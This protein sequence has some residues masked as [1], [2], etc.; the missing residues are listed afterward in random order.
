MHK[1]ESDFSPNLIKCGE[2]SSTEGV[3]SL[4][5]CLEGEVQSQKQLSIAQICELSE[6]FNECFAKIVKDDICRAAQSIRSL[7]GDEEVK[8]LLRE[9]AQR[10]PLPNRGEDVSSFQKRLLLLKSSLAGVSGDSVL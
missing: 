5:E 2:P 1:N 9:I 4:L 7:I 3:N 6:M 10:L 8:R